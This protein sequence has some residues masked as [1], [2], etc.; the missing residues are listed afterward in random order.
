[1]RARSVGTISLSSTHYQLSFLA[2]SIT[3]LVTVTRAAEL[4]KLVNKCLSKA[5]TIQLKSDDEWD[6]LKAQLLIQID[7]ALQPQPLNFEL[8]DIKV[9]IPHIIPKPGMPLA[10][11]A[12]YAIFIDRIC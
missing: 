9:H 5:S 8:F 4:Q 11:E 1:L 12:Q 3:Y 10:T 7:A 2:L 6:L